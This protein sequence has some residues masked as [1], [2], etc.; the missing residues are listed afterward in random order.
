M[1]TKSEKGD[2]LDLI[3]ETGAL[4]KGTF[5]L[6]SGKNSG[7]YFDSRKLSMHPQA[8]HII[9]E[10]F[11][12]QMV[13][14]GVNHVGAVA[15]AAVPLAA[16][17]AASTA[18]ISYQAYGFIIP[19]NPKDHGPVDPLPGHP[20]SPAPRWPSSTTSSPPETPSSEPP[21]TAATPQASKW[22]SP[23]AYS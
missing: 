21:N 11:R 1:L 16:L 4:R 12:T 9:T 2:L 7:W 22:P 8:A 18:R 15:E 13:L 20:P 10:A 6:S 5:V 3:T 14:T 19:K 23:C 17:L